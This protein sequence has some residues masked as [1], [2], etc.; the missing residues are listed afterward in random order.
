MSEWITDRKPREDDGPMI[1][2]HTT[3]DKNDVK[4][5]VQTDSQINRSVL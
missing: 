2:T 5:A 1:Y 4:T 3:G